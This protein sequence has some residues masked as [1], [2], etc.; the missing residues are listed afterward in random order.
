MVVNGFGM[1]GYDKRFRVELYRIFLLSLVGKRYFRNCIK[2]DP[3][4]SQSITLNT[5]QGLCAKSQLEEAFELF[6]LERQEDERIQVEVPDS[7][8][9]SLHIVFKA[10]PTFDSVI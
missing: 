7:V 8:N 6:F 9:D 10:I 5:L 1:V 4:T 2:G 3:T